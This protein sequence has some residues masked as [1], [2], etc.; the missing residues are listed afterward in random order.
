MDMKRIAMITPLMM[1]SFLGLG[2]I[3]ADHTVVDRYDDIPQIYIDKVRE[4]WLSYAGES[5]SGAI[6]A[7][8]LALENLD[9]RYAVSVTEEGTPQPST[10]ANLRVSR[11]TWGDVNNQ[12]GWIYSYGEEDW[13]TSTTAIARTKAGLDYCGTNGP[14]LSA[15]GFGWCWDPVGWNPTATAD[16]AYGVHWTGHTKGGP[17]GDLP[18]GLDAEDLT[19][20][21]NHIS[22]DS[23]LN[24]TQSYIDYCNLKGYKTKVFFTTGPVDG[25]TTGELR[26][27]KQVKYDHI[28]K[29]VA[30]NSDRILF[31]YAD[32][33]CYDNNNNPTT[34]TWNGKTYYTI[35]PSNLTPTI[36]AYHISEA[37]AL[38]L[39]KAMWWMLARI[40][41]WDG[42]VTGIDDTSND[43]S[44]I[45]T[46]IKEGELWIHLPDGL[47]SGKSDL[48][49]LDG[50]LKA[51]KHNNSDLI[52]FDTSNLSAG[53]YIL[54]IRHQTGVKSKKIILP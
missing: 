3:I 8:L 32:I 50:I 24:A 16:A 28:R 5:H 53:L 7:G 33:L 38:R 11:A 44:E 30:L 36:E 26:W 17:D 39:A 48:Y 37:G 20:T 41:G 21:G 19:T 43:S 42:G 47:F 1:V 51:S 31:D 54:V 34:G 6:R 18:W 22:M 46:E 23:Y 29:F 2:Q 35:S 9:S 52:S 13:F 49:S 45:W 15:I 10:A 40:A 25:Y 12:N 4:M 27:E 14:V